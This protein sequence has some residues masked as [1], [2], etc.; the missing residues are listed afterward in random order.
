ME[1]WYDP[2]NGNQVMAVCSGGT[3]SKVWESR[4]FNKLLVDDSSPACPV[5]IRLGRDCRLDFQEDRID[6]YES[7]NSVVPAPNPRDVRIA[8]L[9]A[10]LANDSISYDEL[11]DLLRG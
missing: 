5:V 8:L 11:K 9:R 7:P 2:A 1:L 3:T 6:V 4:G 10:K